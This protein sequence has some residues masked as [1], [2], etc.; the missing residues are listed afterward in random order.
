MAF[1]FGVFLLLP[2][3]CLSAYLLI[4]L[5]VSLIIYLIL[6]LS[7]IYQNAN[8]NTYWCV[9]TVNETQNTIFCQYITGFASFYDLNSDPHQVCG[10]ELFNNHF[11]NLFRIFSQLTNIVNSLGEQVIEY[12]SKRLHFLKSC[13]GKRQC[14]LAESKLSL[15]EIEEQFEN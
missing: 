3:I 14:Q 9:R 8:N 15:D 1:T 10:N 5:A 6:I 4:Y 12:Y 13:N 7:I 2:G 11:I